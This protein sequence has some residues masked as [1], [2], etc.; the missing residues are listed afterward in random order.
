MATLVRKKE[1]A[2]SRCVET[3]R[4]LSKLTEDHSQLQISLN[5]QVKARQSERTCQ[6]SKLVILET[7]NIILT[8]QLDRAS[9]KLQR[10]Q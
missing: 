7:T 9:M 8:K 3:Q 5:D 10:S 4:L 6:Q 1:E 2:D